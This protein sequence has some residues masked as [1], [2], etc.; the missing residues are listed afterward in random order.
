MT[1]GTLW[2]PTLREMITLHGL[3]DLFTG[4][5]TIAP[6][7]GEI[8]RVPD[9]ALL[10]LAAACRACVTEDRADVVILWGGPGRV[11]G[12]DSARCSG[13]GP[14]F[15]RDGNARHADGCV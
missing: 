14:L 5:R 12:A 3:G 6:T 8:A 9:A 2:A 7:G 10:I 15:G 13:A 11:V 1:G 4:V